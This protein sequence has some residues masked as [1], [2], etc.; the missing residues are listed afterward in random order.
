[1]HFLITILYYYF[2]VLTFIITITIHFQTPGQTKYKG[3]VD[4][5][6]QLWKE[7]GIRS[8]YRGTVPTL[9]RDV[10]GS[11]AYFGAYVMVKDKL[12]PAGQ[13]GQLGIMRTLAAGGK[14]HI[15]V[16]FLVIYLIF[17]NSCYSC[18]I[19]KIYVLT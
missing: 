13:E 16:C 2:F 5:F 1:M 6:R 7:G 12:T 10:P 15:Y 18:Y 9:L 14:K 17:I 19:I 4:A 3:S 11:A 8:L